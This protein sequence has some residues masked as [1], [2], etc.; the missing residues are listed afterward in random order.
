MRALRP[1]HFRNW[2]QI[3]QNV[4]SNIEHDA[5]Y[6]KLPGSNSQVSFFTE[7]QP[8]RAP[9]IFKSNGSEDEPAIKGI[10]IFVD[11]TSLIGHPARVST[12]A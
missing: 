1:E 7:I 6:L 9:K 8:V 3:V 11:I 5:D 12:S 10:F 4:D 2:P